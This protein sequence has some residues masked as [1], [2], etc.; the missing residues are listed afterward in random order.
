MLCHLVGT[1]WLLIQSSH[2]NKGGL[3]MGCPL[4]KG[5]QIKMCD[6]FSCTLVLEVN[7]LENTCSTSGWEKCE[8][9]LAYQKLKRKINLYN[10]MRELNR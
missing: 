6:A 2:R 5:N 9:Y 10:Y 4:L 7:K 1:N 8:F 3:I